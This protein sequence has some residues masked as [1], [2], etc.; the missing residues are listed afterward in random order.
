MKDSQHLGIPENSCHEC[1]AITAAATAAARHIGEFCFVGHKETGVKRGQDTQTDNPE[2]WRIWKRVRSTE[3]LDG[4]EE[5]VFQVVLRFHGTAQDVIP[6]DE[7]RTGQMQKSGRQMI[8]TE[9]II[10]DSGQH[11]KIHQVQRR[12]ESYNFSNWAT[13]S[14]TSWERYPERFNASLS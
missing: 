10:G 12:V 8:H 2:R 13:L 6:K 3:S 14:C 7:E 1:L 9:L 5:P 11:M 4:K